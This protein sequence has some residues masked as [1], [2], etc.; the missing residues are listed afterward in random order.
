MVVLGLMLWW[1]LR[2]QES[3][4]VSLSQICIFPNGERIQVPLGAE[5]PEGAVLEVNP[6]ET[7]PA[8]LQG[9]NGCNCEH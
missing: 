9:L 2:D 6:Y 3:T 8:Q 4:S 1:L 5:C 7:E